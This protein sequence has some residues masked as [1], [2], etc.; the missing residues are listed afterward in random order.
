M[1]VSDDRGAPGGVMVTFPVGAGP[2][3][4]DA[5]G[6]SGP[7][8][9]RGQVERLREDAWRLRDDAGAEVGPGDEVRVRGALNVVEIDGE[10]ECSMRPLEVHAL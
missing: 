7:G 4:M 10:P 2:R 1:Y 6:G 5:I 9:V 3:T 8:A